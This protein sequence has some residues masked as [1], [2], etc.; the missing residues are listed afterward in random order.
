MGPRALRHLTEKSQV[1]SVPVSRLAVVNGHQRRQAAIL[2]Q[3]HADGRGNADALKRCRLLGRKFDEVVIDDKWQARSEVLDG[4]PA[5]I[6]KAVI[7]D[8]AGRSLH[9]P[10]AP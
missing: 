9:A 3:R 4:K 7:A 10:I 5:E 1:R 6:S 8:N 2:D